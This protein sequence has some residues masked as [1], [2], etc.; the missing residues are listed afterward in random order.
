M[1]RQ[2]VELLHNAAA[3]RHDPLW[4]DG[5]SDVGDH[6]VIDRVPEQRQ[7]P[8]ARQSSNLGVANTSIG[9]S[10]GKR[11]TDR[12][13]A[14]GEELA[15]GGAQLAVREALRGASAQ[16]ASPRLPHW[17]HRAER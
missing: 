8:D 14:F 15:A 6:R 1:C 4:R 3:A 13:R 7:S 12:L 10:N 16:A 2:G 5:V 11:L 9:G 17:L